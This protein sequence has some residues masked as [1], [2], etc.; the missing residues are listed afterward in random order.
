MQ[1][2]LDY[3]TAICR[4][5]CATNWS[6]ISRRLRRLSFPAMF[7]PKYSGHCTRALTLLRWGKRRDQWRAVM[8]C[9]ELLVLFFAADIRQEAGKL[10]PALGPVRRSS[11]TWSR[12]NYAH[13][14]TGFRR[15]VHHSLIRRSK[16]LSQYIPPRV[17]VRASENRSL[18]GPLRIELVRTGTPKTP[19]CTRWWRLGSG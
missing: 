1:V 6:R 10:L 16:R 4:L 5:R 8:S 7:C 9:G 12:Y 15:G 3:A 13:S 2:R 11:F 17:P 19:V 14:S 18:S